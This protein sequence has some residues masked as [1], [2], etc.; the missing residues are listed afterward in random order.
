MVGGPDVAA[1]VLPSAGPDPIPMA[2]ALAAVLGYARGR[3]PLFFRS[4]SSPQGRWVQVLAY[5]MD[6]FD[7]QPAEAADGPTDRD[8]LLAEGLHGRLDPAAWSAVRARLTAAWPQLQ[9]LLDR[10]AGRA[11]WELPDDEFSVLAEP[12]TVGAALRSLAEGTGARHVV[13]A[14]HHRHPALVPLLDGVTLR[15]LWGHLREG[16]SGP[17]AVV[18]R[19]LVANAGAF[20]VLETATATLLGRRLTRLRLHDVLLWLSGSL[21]MT[22]AVAVGRALAAGSEQGLEALLPA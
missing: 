11:F 13:A 14:L 9:P 3:R 22:H 4:P 6:R 17:E 5:A 19:E 10:A 16:D 12:G 1:L 20:A 8:V 2:T 18:H 21:R 7:G 15:Q